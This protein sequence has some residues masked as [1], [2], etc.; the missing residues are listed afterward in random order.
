MSAIR[1][2]DCRLVR[3]SEDRLSARVRFGPIFRHE[4]Q[5][6]ISISSH[7]LFGLGMARTEEAG[8]PLRI[9]LLLPSAN[10]ATGGRSPGFT[11]A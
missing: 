7:A 11:P 3:L 1:R 5:W 6:V 10:A 4:A 8:W 2:L 9:F